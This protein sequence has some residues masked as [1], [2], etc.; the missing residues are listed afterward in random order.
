MSSGSDSA[1]PTQDTVDFAQPPVEKLPE[2]ESTPTAN[3]QYHHKRTQSTSSTSSLNTDDIF[4]LRDAVFCQFN[5]QIKN[6]SFQLIAFNSSSDNSKEDNSTAQHTSSSSGNLLL[7]FEFTKMKIGV[8]IT[9]PNAYACLCH[10][11][12]GIVVSLDCSITNSL[13][14]LL[15]R[16]PSKATNGTSPTNSRHCSNATK[17]SH[18]E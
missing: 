12:Q 10:M 5:F 18:T 14:L 9:N 2:V 3:R 11:N 16:L 7:E 1:T 17:V 4:L 15:S 13:L 6:S 8:D